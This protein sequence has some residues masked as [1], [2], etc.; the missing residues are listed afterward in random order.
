M[1]ELR[2]LS[3][4]AGG[5]ILLDK[6]SL[7]VNA[8]EL[9]VLVGPSGTGKSV[10]LRVIA[11]L[12]DK[13]TPH[14]AISGTLQ[15][16][17]RE[18]LSGRRREPVGVV[19]QRFALF[20]ELS[21]SDNLRFALDHRRRPAN[22]DDRARLVQL[23]RR[24]GIDDLP[25]VAFCSVG[26]QQRVAFARAIAYDAPLV[27]YDEPTSGLDPRSSGEVVQLIR[28]TVTE[29]GK[30]ALVV[31]HDYAEL[32]PVADRIVLLDSEN[33]TLREVAADEVPALMQRR[34]GFATPADP[35]PV[36]A[37]WRRLPRVVRAIL[38]LAA[39]LFWRALFTVGRLVEELAVAALHL[40]PRWRSTRWGLHYL[41]H[42]LKLVGF[43]S[44]I[45]YVGAAGLIAGFTATFF[46]FRFFPYQAYTQ[47]LIMDDILGSLG[48]ALYRVAV[49][50]IVSILL[51]AR[52]G[53]AIASDVGSRCY[54]NTL[55][56]MRSMGAEPQRYLL[57]GVLWAMLIASPLLIA[58]AFWLSKVASVLTFSAL[59]PQRSLYE[60]ELGF[61]SQLREVGRIFYAG[62]GFAVVKALL[63][64]FVIA[65]RG[66]FRGADPKHS[67]HDV[68][69][70][71]TET[72][73]GATLLSL[74]LHAVIAIFEFDVPG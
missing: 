28:E 54:T 27:V 62:T 66:Y 5:R 13:Q 53:A 65:A 2:D 45:V 9:V 69:S 46:T 55:D 12:I 43:F 8:G 3:V 71:I 57:W 33:H 32:L 31:T 7:R 29:H 63:C 14:F 61:H 52:C 26:Q 15:V 47:P 72:I 17:G 64:G 56:A 20:D 58:L 37:A 59:F 38:A 10:L 34:P 74:V 51:A 25:I 19:F 50:V 49:P 4:S 42:Y 11:G 41:G 22:A 6:A 60:W 67:V 1:L 16:N 36:R 68:N 35:A 70:A 18:I 48:F 73:I 24:L 23:T 30:T 39:T 21:V 40:V 44:T